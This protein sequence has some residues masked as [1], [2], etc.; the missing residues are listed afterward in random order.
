MPSYDVNR[1]AVTKAREL[2]DAGTYDDTTEWS[3][4]APSTEQ[5][6]DELDRRG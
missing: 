1:A 2:I 3:D 5:G 6:N 4:A